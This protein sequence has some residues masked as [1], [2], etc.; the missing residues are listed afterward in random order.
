MIA[1]VKLPLMFYRFSMLLMNRFL[2]WLT[3]SGNSN[4]FVI[5]VGLGVCF[6]LFGTFLPVFLYCIE[7]DPFFFSVE[8]S[9]DFFVIMIICYFVSMNYFFVFEYKSTFLYSP[10]SVNEFLVICILQNC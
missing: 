5:F 4:L 2:I 3:K 8:L 7:F 6:D 10:K 9:F 1:A